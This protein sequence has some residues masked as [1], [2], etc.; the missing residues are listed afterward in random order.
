MES[1]RW[2]IFAVIYL[3]LL[4]IVL[5]LLAL[6]REVWRCLFCKFWSFVLSS[7]SA[8][9]FCLANGFFFYFGFS[10]VGSGS[11]PCVSH[12]FV[13]SRSNMVSSLASSE[14]LI[15]SLD[16]ILWCRLLAIISVLVI[17]SLM[18]VWNLSGNFSI[19]IGWQSLFVS[20]F[21]I[22]FLSWGVVSFSSKDF[23]LSKAIT[24]CVVGQ[25]VADNCIGLYDMVV[26]W[27]QIWCLDGAMII[28]LSAL[29]NV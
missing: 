21:T 13:F 26:A 24:W 4:L 28:V 8:F 16:R 5:G 23:L 14:P 3:G 27:T 6:L 29:S 19:F 11:F 15:L 1:R 25:M 9:Y 22:F 7:F 17:G 10:L 20:L 18:L 2:N 12:R